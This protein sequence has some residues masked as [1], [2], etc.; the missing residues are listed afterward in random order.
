MIFIE[1][2]TKVIEFQ[3]LNPIG[4]LKLFDPEFKLEKWINRNDKNEIIT[5]P[6]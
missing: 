5:N 1:E 3:S 4:L 2:F 6:D